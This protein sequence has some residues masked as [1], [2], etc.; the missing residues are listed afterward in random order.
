MII[1][2]IFVVVIK[3]KQNVYAV[4]VRLF[5]KINKTYNIYSLYNNK[6]QNLD[7]NIDHYQLEDIL[8]L[9]KIPSIFDENDLKKAK[10]MVLQTHPDKSQLHPDY[11]LF[12]SKAY[13]MLYGI[14]EFKNKQ[15][16]EPISYD[17]EN[18]QYKKIQDREK[19]QILDQFLSKTDLKDNKK[20]QQWFNEQ[21]E[22]NKL[23]TEEQTN[24]YGEWLKSND[25]LEEQREIHHTQL[26]EEIEKK[27][28]HLRAMIVHKYISE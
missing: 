25:D 11:F 19:T 22:K 28:K 2:V 6:M 3:I 4:V 24:G 14:W 8:N 13:K 16:K 21:F 5:L 10:K 12:F 7:L 20:F 15:T 9:F 17:P 23:E 1:K 18:F 27:K 26:G